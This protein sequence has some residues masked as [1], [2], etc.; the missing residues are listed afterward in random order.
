[1]KELFKNHLYIS[2]MVADIISNFGDVLYYLALMNYVVSIRNSSIAI[3]L[4][5]LSDKIICLISNKEGVIF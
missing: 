5:S 2:I 4:I 3:S 1:M